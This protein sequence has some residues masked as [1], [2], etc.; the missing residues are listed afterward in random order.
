MP[1]PSQPAT[2][3]RDAFEI[4][5]SEVADGMSLAYLREGVGGYSLLLVHGYPETMRIWW[6]NVKPLVAAGYEVIVPDL[7]GY[8]DSDLSERD[9]YVTPV[10]KAA[11]TFAWEASGSVGMRHPSTPQRCFRDIYM[12]AG[13]MVFDDR[14]YHELAKAHLGLEPAPF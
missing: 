4:R 2:P 3:P 12:A 10:T 7:R 13:H 6:R 11:V 9:N 1:R 8:G 5:H 14:N